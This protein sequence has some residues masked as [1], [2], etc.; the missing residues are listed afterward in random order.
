MM[1]IFAAYV[2]A[3]LQLLFTMGWL[4]QKSHFSQ[5]CIIGVTEV[6]TL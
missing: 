6:K 2:H 1:S 4:V 5:G 3:Q